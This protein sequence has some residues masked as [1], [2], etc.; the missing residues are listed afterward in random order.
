MNP[1]LE[2]F[3]KISGLPTHHVAINFPD[4]SLEFDGVDNLGKRFHI[5]SAPTNGNFEAATVA[6]AE[7]AKDM[8][9][10]TGFSSLAA[11]IRQ[12]LADL[13]SQ[14]GQVHTE[15]LAA[16][17]DGQAVNQQAQAMVKQV[18]S[19]VADMRAALGLTSNQ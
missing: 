1:L 16:L 13:K 3:R 5:R 6:L 4:N 17:Q 7:K 8:A 9:A 2:I 12:Q 18:Q 11:D 14:N 10:V 15:L 19:E